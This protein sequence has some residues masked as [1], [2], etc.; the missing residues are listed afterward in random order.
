MES[1]EQKILVQWF[2]LRFSMLT[3]MYPKNSLIY[4]KLKSRKRKQSYLS[5]RLPVK[6]F[7]D[8][9]LFAMIAFIFVY[10]CKVDSEIFAKLFYN[11]VPFWQQLNKFENAGKI[12]RKIHHGICLGPVKNCFLSQLFRCLIKQWNWLKTNTGRVQSSAEVKSL[13]LTKHAWSK[14]SH[15]MTMLLFI[16]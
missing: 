8:C 15:T 12:M 9:F 16:E 4:L 13:F 3:R 5:N 10:T 7:I 14:S 1:H 2:S 6:G 11:W